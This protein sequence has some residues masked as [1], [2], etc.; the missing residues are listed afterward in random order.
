MS[1][2]NLAPFWSDN[3]ACACPEVMGAVVAVNSG[4][5]RS[6]GSD[7]WSIN[8][9]RKFS[10]VFETDVAVFPVVTG[11]ASNALALSA[12]TPPYGKIYC[13]EFAHIHTDE[14]SAPELFTGGAKLI[15]LHGDNAKIAA[16]DLASAIR[17]RGNV[18]NAQPWTVSITQATEGGT[19]YRLDEIQAIAEVS[20]AH[21]LKLHMDGAR[22][23]NG[24]VSLGISPAEMT[25]KSGVDVLSFGGTKNG[26]IAAEAVLFFEAGLAQ[27][28][29]Y[30]Q[31]RAGQLLSKMRFVSAQLEAYLADEVWLR[32]ARQ[33]NA[34][35]A[36]LS[37]GL[38]ALPGVELVYPTEANEVFARLPR[39]AVE[40]LESA[41]IAVNEGEL[42][43]SAA[44]FVTTWNTEPDDVDA[45]LAAM[46][47]QHEGA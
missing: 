45:L 3:I 1:K 25:W 47:G 23:A 24:L 10:E 43:G 31:K 21:G 17:G 7:S 12:L 34:M 20:R 41:G 29:P 42:D 14:C 46:A 28:F 8:L 6:Y 16:A 27:G 13:H 40:I 4:T 18:H 11:T 9:Q 36:R 32:N 26:C 35:A 19:V 39:S 30:L 15:A 22:F 2:A 44:R 38:A 37:A 33:A 5:A